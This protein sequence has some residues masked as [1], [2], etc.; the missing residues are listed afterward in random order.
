MGLDNAVTACDTDKEE[1][2]IQVISI[3]TRRLAGMISEVFAAMYMEK[4]MVRLN[5][6]YFTCDGDTL[7]LVATDASRLAVSF[8]AV[9]CSPFDFI[10]G[11]E[12]VMDL[13]KLLRRKGNCIITVY[14]DI[15]KFSGPSDGFVAIPVDV[16]YPNW[17]RVVPN[18][19]AISVTCDRTHLIAL[20]TEAMKHKPLVNKCRVEI[21]D[22]VTVAGTEI[23][24]ECHC[25]KEAVRIG[26]FTFYVNGK[27]IL[28][29]L[30]SAPGAGP[31]RL[32]FGDNPIRAFVIDTGSDEAGYH[33]LV[34]MVPPGD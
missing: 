7:C 10:L 3:N 26:E 20:F 6:I 2:L 22:N 18:D 34:P 19:F 29:A 25:T 12:T 15:V 8:E 4:D 21:G 9:H 14:D 28:D 23:V 17:K 5:G 11:M 30:K 16:Q 32:R 31:I 24:G 1:R 27:F 13:N 33:V